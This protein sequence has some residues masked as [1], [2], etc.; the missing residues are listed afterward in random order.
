M[1][2]LSADSIK[3]TLLPFLLNRGFSEAAA[4][5]IADIFVENNLEGVDSHGVARFPNLIRAIDTGRVVATEGPKQIASFGAWEQWDGLSGSGQLNAKAS[6][7]RAIEL[8]K[9][10]GLGCVALRRTN[11]WMRGGT[12]GRHAAVAGFAGICWTNTMPNMPPWGS[13]APRLGNN[14]LVIAIPHADG[15]IVMDMAMTQFSYGKLEQHR[16]Y[17]TELPVVGGKDADGNLTT[18]PAAIL[19]S[20]NLLPAGFWKGSGLAFALD[21]LGSLLASGNATSDI[22]KMEKEHDI[23]QVFIA[24]DL[25]RSN[26]QEAIALRVQEAIAWLKG[27]DS[28][29]VRYPG[30]RAANTRAERLVSGIPIP[31]ETWNAIATLPKKPH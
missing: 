27:D 18:D 21:L 26:D 14:P 24:F 25:N 31:E 1:P 3:Q 23:S 16:I 20:G 12:Y 7:D 6:M 15:P 2:T 30:E 9:Q 28:E 19:E 17:E 5:T 29:N 8:A 10:F 11:H 13:D 4:N 22:A